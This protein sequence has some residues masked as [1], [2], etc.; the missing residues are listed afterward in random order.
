MDIIVEVSL[1][2]QF[3]PSMWNDFCRR[4]MIY[5]KKNLTFNNIDNIWYIFLGLGVHFYIDK[6]LLYKNFEVL[7]LFF[8]IVFNNKKMTFLNF[9]GHLPMDY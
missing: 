8:K 2:E 3:F 1:Y 5:N 6:S 4:G 9:G 7:R